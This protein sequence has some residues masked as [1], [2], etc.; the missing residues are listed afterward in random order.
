MV[1]AVAVIQLVV[2]MV[3]AVI[4]VRAVRGDLEDP[5]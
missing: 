3:F 2:S 5:A 4:Y 1:S